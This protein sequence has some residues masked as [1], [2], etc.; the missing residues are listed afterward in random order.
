MRT[1][2]LD[3]L[4]DVDRLRAADTGE[5]RRATEELASRLGADWQAEEPSPAEDALPLLHTPTGLRFVAIPGGRF[6]MG[7]SEADMEEAAEHVDWTSTIAAI[8]EG[9]AKMARPVH[10]VE[11]RPFLA[12]RTLLLD[13]G[14][15]QRLSGGKIAYDSVSR[16]EA[17]EL[18]RAA[19]FRLPS[20]TELEWIARDGGRCHFTLDVA[21]ARK[22]ASRF[23][24][25]QVFWGEWAED[26]WHPSYDG[27]PST[28]TPWLDGAEQ[29]VYRHAGGPE[30]MQSRDELLFMLAGVR[31]E[32]VQLPDFTGARPARDLP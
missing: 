20:E 25:E 4:E 5:R 10:P 6:E 21:T 12:S 23:G 30:M 18:V 27:A 31:G 29:G 14:L 22:P 16:E 1:T 19:G 13:V 8:A 28:S 17:R 11:V 2:V 24:V 26:D 9:F 3:P 15:I 32:G 7:L